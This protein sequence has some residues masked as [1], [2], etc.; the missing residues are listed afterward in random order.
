MYICTY[1]I[2]AEPWA[3]VEHSSTISPCA[4]VPRDGL[5]ASSQP[6]IV[7]IELTKVTL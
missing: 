7:M 3:A 4:H 5:S 1:I 6:L 2:G